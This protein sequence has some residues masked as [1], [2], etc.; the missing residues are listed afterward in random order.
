M[1]G[2]AWKGFWLSLGTGSTSL[3]QTSKFQG[4]AVKLTVLSYSNKKKHP[5]RPGRPLKKGF[6][7]FEDNS[8]TSTCEAALTHWSLS[9]LNSYT[10]NWFPNESI[11]KVRGCWKGWANLHPQGCANFHPPKGTKNFVL[12]TADCRLLSSFTGITALR[13]IPVDSSVIQRPF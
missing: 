12:R 8:F 3:I 2:S 11:C 13:S 10:R 4:K 7:H 1:E 6:A 5:A 9:T